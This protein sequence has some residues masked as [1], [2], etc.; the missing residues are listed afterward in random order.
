MGGF[1]PAGTGFV[2]PLRMRP[3]LSYHHG[4]N[5]GAGY[6]KALGSSSL[7]PKRLPLRFPVMSTLEDRSLSQQSGGDPQTMA[8]FRFF[9]SD[10]PSEP[11][12]DQHACAFRLTQPSF[13]HA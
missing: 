4:K 11:L 2:S 1:A 7:L 8:K 12:N 3:G 6:A 5:T 9:G 13:S 10:S